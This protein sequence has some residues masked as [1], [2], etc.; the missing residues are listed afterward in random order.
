MPEV[1]LLYFDGCPHWQVTDERLRRLADEHGGVRVAYRTVDTPE[2]AERVGFRGSPTV[3]VDGIDPFAT[4]DEP[5]GLSCRVYVTEDGPQ[6][7]PTIEQL[8]S[9]L[10]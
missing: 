2:E 7:S 9:V 10:T 5:T 8:R 4:G 1:T 3:L 6:G